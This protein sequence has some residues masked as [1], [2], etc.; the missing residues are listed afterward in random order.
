MKWYLKRSGRKGED[1][2]MIGRSSS[3]EVIEPGPKLKG[4]DGVGVSVGVGIVLKPPSRSELDSTNGGGL[5]KYGYV[6]R[7]EKLNSEL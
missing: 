2:Y 1:G 4:R 7:S 3:I 5:L 6:R